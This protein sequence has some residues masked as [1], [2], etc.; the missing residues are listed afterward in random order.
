MFNISQTEKTLTRPGRR[1][2]TGAG[3]SSFAAMS[4]WIFSP[5]NLLRLS[6]GRLS[7]R[8]R[9]WR[10]GRE[11][12]DSVWWHGE[13]NRNIIGISWDICCIFFWFIYVFVN[14][15]LY[16]FICVYIYI[17]SIIYYIIYLFIYLF[18]EYIL[19]LYMYMEVC[20]ATGYPKSS[21]SSIYMYWNP[22]FGITHG[23]GNLHIVPP[24]KKNE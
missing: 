24:P 21:T 10:H 13:D 5:E 16:L 11:C 20:Y 3:L 2:V 23:P 14:L 1:T 6:D 22:W 17:L 9:P 4:W 18:T 19:W 7:S 12:L 15:F 8:S